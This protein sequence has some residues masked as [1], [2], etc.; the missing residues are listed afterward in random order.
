MDLPVS[1]QRALGRLN[2]ALDALD[3]A[4]ERRA[5]A[6]A[7]RGDA[8]AEYAVLQDDRSRL[9]VELDAALARVRALDRVAGDVAG[10]VERAGAT[11]RGVLAELAPAG[12]APPGAA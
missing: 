4:A 2:G 3:A 10:R 1:L 8:D 7:S 9:A 6:D 5:E 12:S 11:V